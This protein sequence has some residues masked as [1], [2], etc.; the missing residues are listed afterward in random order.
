MNGPNWAP[1]PGPNEWAQMD[2]GQAQM[3][4]PHGQT[5]NDCTRMGANECRP[6]SHSRSAC[7]LSLSQWACPLSLSLWPIQSSIPTK[8]IIFSH[9]LK[10]HNLF[11]HF[12]FR[13]SFFPTT[14]SGNLRPSSRT[15]LITIRLIV[16]LIITHD[17]I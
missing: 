2:P 7:L 6:L 10:T 15:I 11:R 17:K 5:P 8:V 13:R 16:F 12:L 14:N 1:F 3:N 4:R 9:C